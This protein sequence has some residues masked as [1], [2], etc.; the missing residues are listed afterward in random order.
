MQDASKRLTFISRVFLVVLV[1]GYLACVATVWA[2]FRLQGD[3]WWFATL[4][5]YGPRWIYVVPFIVLVPVVLFLQPRLILPLGCTGAVAIG[6]LMGFYVPWRTWG[7]SSPTA[8]RVLSFNIER[9]QATGQDFSTLLNQNQP[10]LIAVQE[11]AGVGPWTDWWPEHHKWHTIHRGEML[12]ASR[13]PIKRVE[14]SYSR[15][16]SHRQPI[17]NA[18]YCVLATPQG[19]IGFCN[20]HFDT[21]RRALS[22]VL[23]RKSFLNL[24]NA[25][26]AD[27]RLEC[28][29]QES[30]DLLDWLNRFPEPKVI[31]GDFN[32]TSDSPI[33]R[34]DWNHFANAFQQAGWGFGFT[35]QTIIRRQQYGL[36]IDHVLTD[37]N[38]NPVRAW[39]GPDLGSDHLP[40]LANI[41]TEFPLSTP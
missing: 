3:R 32:M 25:A 16:P 28:R 13:F 26:Y 30:A 22:T 12:I 37:G 10:D 33:Y 40:L 2:L 19:D 5:M 23:D 1:Y 8:L 21:P 24:D 38:W 29:S 35:K 41:A 4:L 14:V 11:C 6:S 9:Y 36:R 7:Q 17:L 18:I 27:Y 31:A 34:R 15:F 20:L 39:V